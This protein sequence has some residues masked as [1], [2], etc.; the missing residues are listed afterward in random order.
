MTDLLDVNVWLALAD[1]NHQHHTLAA[2]Y[3]AEQAAPTVVFTRVTMLAFLRL[4]TRPGVLTRALSADEAWRLYRE[5]RSRE[6]IGFLT[7]SPGLDEV[8]ETLTMSEGF[9]HRLWTDSFL[10]ALAIATG[11]R[12]VS[13]D[14]DF[15]RFVGLSFLHLK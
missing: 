11:S 3:W 4:S 9:T 13:F 6:A 12:L 8:Y 7:D 2:S 15:G 5:Y 1:E 14:V 10:A